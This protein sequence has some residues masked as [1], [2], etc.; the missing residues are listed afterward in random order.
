MAFPTLIDHGT[1]GI[2]SSPS[3][4]SIVFD[5]PSSQAGDY[6]LVYVMTAWASLTAV[7]PTSDHSQGLSFGMIHEN[8]TIYTNTYLYSAFDA[9]GGTNWQIDAGVV[10][11]NGGAWAAGFVHIRNATEGPNVTFTEGNTN[12]ADAILTT[13]AVESGVLAFL[14]DDTGIEYYGVNWSTTDG[15]DP[16]VGGTVLL[17]D[18]NE[19]SGGFH[20]AYYPA[21]SPANPYTF[22]GS[23]Q[24]GDNQIVAVEIEGSDVPNGGPVS[25]IVGVNT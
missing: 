14:V 7:T 4:L 24:F 23:G 3:E 20:A 9:N 18:G 21:I 6:F 13:Q 2:M 1:S 22:T 5:I 10:N 16:D 12:T 25:W 15:Y 11:V 17:Q 8:E 19:V